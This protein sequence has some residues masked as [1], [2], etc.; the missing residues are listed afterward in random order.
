LRILTQVVTCLATQN[1]RVLRIGIIMGFI[2][3]TGIKKAP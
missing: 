2:K 3:D 1:D